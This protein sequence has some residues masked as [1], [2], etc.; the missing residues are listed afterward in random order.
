MQIIS[1]TSAKFEEIL[2]ADPDRVLRDAQ[3]SLDC[4]MDG[5]YSRV[6]LFGAGGL[7]R[8]V[9]T[10]LQSAGI[11]PLAFADNNQSTWGTEVCGLSVL[12]P[13]EAISRYADNSLFVVTIWRALATETMGRRI[14]TLIELGA[15]RVC[16]VMPLFCKYQD[17]FLPYYSLDMPHKLLA[18][19]SEIK[20]AYAL[21]EDD[22][23]R[24][25]FEKQIL[26]R[27]DPERWDLD[28][29]SDQTE[30]FPQD[31]FRLGDKEVYVDVGGYDGD[32]ARIFLSLTRNKVNQIHIIEADPAT[33]NRLETWRFTLPTD[34]R[35]RVRLY[36]FAASDCN[37]ILSFSATSD[38]DSHLSISGH[39]I[40]IE[41]EQLDVILE[42][43]AAPT[44]V[45][46]DIEGAEV[47]ALTGMSRLINEHHPILAI[48]LYHRQKDL[49]T[50]PNLIDS[51]TDGYRYFLKAHSLDGWDLVL[52]A[53]PLTRCDR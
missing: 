20:Q 7:G 47:A 10:T 24:S 18:S 8:L 37:G 23:S 36:N 16:S 43:M 45:K 25:E 27:L 12:S 3:Y 44:L 50:I 53:V 14:T 5:G 9:A 38:V 19:R 46:M 32:T 6:V 39:G 4:L 22:A 2:Q 29:V 15:Q 42:D 33:F 34:L 49:W 40:E 31:L 1:H 51:F 17:L 11:Q 26:W 35:E 21:L 48:C 52:Y 30:Y 28:Q 41:C 13:T